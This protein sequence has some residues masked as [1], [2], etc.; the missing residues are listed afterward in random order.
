MI[1]N[2]AF[3]ILYEFGNGDNNGESYFHIELYM[4]M[5]GRCL[6]S[7]A[8][9]PFVVYEMLSLVDILC[10]IQ[11]RYSAR[12]QSRSCSAIRFF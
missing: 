8:F 2:C 3:S 12:Q 5:L 7:V 10:L 6:L 11:A 4:V 1:Q 9:V